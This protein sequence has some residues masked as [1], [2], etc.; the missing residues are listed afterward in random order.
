M[1]GYSNIPF[2]VA[3]LFSLIPV[4]AL[5][6]VF[7]A[8]CGVYSMLNLCMQHLKEKEQNGRN[9]LLGMAV[10]NRLCMI[11]GL[12]FMYGLKGGEWN[13]E[14]NENSTVDLTI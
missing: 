12:G 11:L 1:L 3:A 13:P 8:L 5:R 7:M 4:K 2:V 14:D 6:W 9:F 10:L